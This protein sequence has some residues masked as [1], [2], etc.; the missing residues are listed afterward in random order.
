MNRSPFLTD[1]FFFF[2]GT[3]HSS[4]LSVVRVLCEVGDVVEK[5]QPVIILEAMKM[6]RTLSA[7]YKGTVTQV[8]CKE[9]ELIKEKAT[10]AV[11]EPIDEE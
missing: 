8:S 7:P 10:L 1:F 5:G 4:P 2:F 9:K 11:I 6:E 3:V